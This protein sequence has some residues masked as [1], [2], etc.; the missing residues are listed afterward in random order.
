VEHL[1]PAV[2]HTGRRFRRG[3]CDSGRPRKPYVVVVTER[4]ELAAGPGQTGIASRRRSERLLVT[5]H[6][7]AAILC[8][9]F[10]EDL[11]RSGVRSVIYNDQLDGGVVLAQDGP[12]CLAKALGSIVSGEDDAE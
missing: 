1:V 7:H 9:D 3:H 2:D 12:G 6:D 11:G 8:S 4:H 5:Y 10:V